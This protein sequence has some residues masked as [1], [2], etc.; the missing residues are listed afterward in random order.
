MDPRGAPNY[1]SDDQSDTVGIEDSWF[2][3]N[4]HID[5]WL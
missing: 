5:E 2:Q 3:E 4:L 1:A